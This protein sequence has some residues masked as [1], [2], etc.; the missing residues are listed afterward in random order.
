MLLSEALQGKYYRSKSRHIEGIIQYAEK[1]DN[2]ATP[3]GVYAYTIQVR[4]YWNRNL[5]YQKPDFYST[6]YVK[7]D[8]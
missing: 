3:D 5:N 7:V 8:E 1:R 6:L 2:V 4:P